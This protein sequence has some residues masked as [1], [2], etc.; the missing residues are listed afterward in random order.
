MLLRP[1]S[2]IQIIDRSFPNNHPLK[3]LRQN[4]VD[5]VDV[6]LEAAEPGKH[7]L[8]SKSTRKRETVKIE[9]ISDDPDSVLSL[10]Q[11]PYASR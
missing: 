1:S 9:D 5:N 6:G 8:F 2:P 11:S 4:V 10:K 3:S 7:L